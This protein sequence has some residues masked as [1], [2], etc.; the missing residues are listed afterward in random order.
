MKDFWHSHS[1]GEHNADQNRPENVFNIW[2][3]QMMGLSIECDPLFDK[4][5]EE[6]DGC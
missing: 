3:V 4:L 5:P 1:V 6:T 2:K